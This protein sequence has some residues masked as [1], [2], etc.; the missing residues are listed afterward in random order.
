MIV[1]IISR[2][3]EIDIKRV[4]VALSG[5]DSSVYGGAP[6]LGVRG[7]SMICHGNSQPRAIRNAIGAA[8]RAVETRLNE[9]IG[10]RLSALAGSADETRAAS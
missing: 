2:D 3:R 6:L 4:E 1:E 8:V 5:L 9:H 7:V 10:E